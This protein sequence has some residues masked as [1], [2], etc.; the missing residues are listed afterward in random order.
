MRLMRRQSPAVL[1]SRVSWLKHKRYVNTKAKLAQNIADGRV[2]VRSYL[3]LELL[4][5]ALQLRYVLFSLSPA[6]LRRE[7][8]L[9]LSTQALELS[10]LGL[11]DGA[12]LYKC[13]S[14]GFHQLLLFARERLNELNTRL[15]YFGHDERECVCVD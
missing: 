1:A 15:K 13:S 12:V 6:I 4:V 10:L 14:F 3:I 8:V 5:L 7:L 9:N 11:C 2:D